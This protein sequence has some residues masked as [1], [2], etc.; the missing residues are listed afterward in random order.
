MTK[1]IFIHDSIF[2]LDTLTSIM[3]LFQCILFIGLLLIF[4]THGCLSAR[5]AFDPSRTVTVKT[6]VGEI[7]GK[8]ETIKFDGVSYDVTEFLGIPYAEP[9]VG[10]NRFKKSLPRAPF[11]AAFSAFDYGATCLQP[12][13]EDLTHKVTIE[14]DCLFLNIFV[15]GNG[16]IIPSKLPVMVWIH[17]GG[18]MYGTSTAYPGDNLGAFG[19]VIVVTINYRLAHIGFL[20]TKE[21]FA[22]FGLW[23]QHLAINWVHDNIKAFGGDEDK[24]TI[25]G[26][27]A[28]SSSVVYQALFPGNKN[29]FQRA[30]AES[31]GITSSWAYST[32]QHADQ[33]FKNFTAEIGCISGSNDDILDCLRNK[34]T[35]EVADVMLHHKLITNNVVPSRD[36]DFV[37][38]HPQ[39]MVNRSSA[40]PESLDVFSNIDFMMGSC[41]IDGA[42]FL[43]YFGSLVNISDLE[44]FKVSRSEFETSFVP[45]TLKYI[46]TNIAHIPEVANKMAV[47]EYTNWTCPDD[48]MARNME[49]I[50]LATDSSMFVPMVTMAQL[51]EGVATYHSSYMYELSTAPTTHIIPV[52]SWLDGPTHA[53]HADDF[54]FVFGFPALMLKLVGTDKRPI[55]YTE[56]DIKVSKYIMAM[57]SNF[58]KTG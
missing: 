19:Q 32:E 3:L 30:I 43:K 18:F 51:H 39:Y 57:W 8:V 29:L 10:A 33:I 38:M 48:N 27:S 42:L 13:G 21:A 58:A 56:K 53:N 55:V 20:R 15:P 36:N 46:F 11:T 37:P 25:F 54:L 24:I 7:V 47:F 52:P 6:P 16:S 2:H 14:E 35:G 9:P 4:T 28:G 22:N 44:H 45:G 31:G 26:E 5:S 12:P 17:G 34:T 1:L 40:R 41:S 49:L 50:D 23:D